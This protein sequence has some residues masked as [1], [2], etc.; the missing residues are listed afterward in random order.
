[1]LT[2]DMITV[3]AFAIYTVIFAVLRLDARLGIGA[4]LA[5]LM[6]AAITLAIGNEDLA[7]RLVMYACYFLASGGILHL[8]D[9]IRGEPKRRKERSIQLYS[10]RRLLVTLRRRRN[11]KP[12]AQQ[13]QEQV[14]GKGSSR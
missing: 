10:K 2:I 13:S 1:M 9:H 4:A 8:I 12:E 11:G 5:L 6:T 7:N 14:L 3:I